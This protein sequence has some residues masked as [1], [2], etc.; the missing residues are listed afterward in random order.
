LESTAEKLQVPVDQVEDKL[1]AVLELEKQLEKENHDLQKKDAFAKYIDA[2]EKIENVGEIAVLTLYVKEVIPD[3]LRELAD[4]FKGEIKDGVAVFATTNAKGD[5]VLLVAC[6]PT[7]IKKGIK[8]G[9]VVNAAAEVVGGR[10]GGRPDLAQA[11][12]K[13]ATKIEEALEKAKE[14]VKNKLK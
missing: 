10:G 5:P 8:A 11:G 3:T 4:R 1:V 14:F 9:D 2:K 13:D 6:T 7:V 12:G